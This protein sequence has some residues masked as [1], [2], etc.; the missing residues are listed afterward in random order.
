YGFQIVGCGLPHHA[1]RLIK[2]LTIVDTLVLIVI[3]FIYNPLLS[4]RAQTGYIVYRI[5]RVDRL[6]VDNS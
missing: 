6:Q 1:E 3:C 2:Q 4:E 5:D